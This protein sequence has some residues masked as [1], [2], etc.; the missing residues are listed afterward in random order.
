MIADWEPFERNKT[1]F[2]VDRIQIIAVCDE[3]KNNKKKNVNAFPSLKTEKKPD[4][5]A[6]S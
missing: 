5:Q 2:C 3:G 1:L 4:S 6:C